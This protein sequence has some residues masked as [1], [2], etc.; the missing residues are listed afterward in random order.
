MLITTDEYHGVDDGWIISE[1]V[2]RHKELGA[3][4]F[5]MVE[6]WYKTDCNFVVMIPYDSN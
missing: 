1:G 5:N 6:N 4:R 3:L 2:W